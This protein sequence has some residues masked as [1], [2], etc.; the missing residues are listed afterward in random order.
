MIKY[1]RFLVFTVLLAVLSAVPAHAQGFIRD[2]EIENTIRAYSTPIFEAA[3]LDPSD[4]EC[5]VLWVPVAPG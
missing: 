4:I 2:A 5:I 3:G 1:I